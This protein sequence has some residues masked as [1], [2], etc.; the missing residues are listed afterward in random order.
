MFGVQFIHIYIYY[1]CIIDFIIY[2]SIWFKMYI[3]LKYIERDKDVYRF[4]DIP[5]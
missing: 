5:L 3:K 2:Y 1:V 4:F